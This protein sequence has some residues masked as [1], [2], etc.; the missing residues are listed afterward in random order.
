MKWLAGAAPEI[1]NTHTNSSTPRSD[2]RLAPSHVVQRRRGVE[3]EVEP[4]A[5]GH[6]RIDAGAFV[7]FVEV[8]DRLSVE[9]D[10]T[11]QPPER[12]AAPDC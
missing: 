3:A 2:D 7:D 11:V 12:A 9:E 6:E 1:S 4:D 10:A 5:V 8:G